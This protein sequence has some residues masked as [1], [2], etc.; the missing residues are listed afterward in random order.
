MHPQAG[1]ITREQS[2]ALGNAYHQLKRIEHRLQMIG[3]NQ[4]HSLPRSTEDL[5]KFAHFGA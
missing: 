3:D 2:D 4:T 5:E 1:W